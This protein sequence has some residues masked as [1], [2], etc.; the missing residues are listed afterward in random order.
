MIKKIAFLFLL[1]VGTNWSLTAQIQ[2]G[3]EFANFDTL[4]VI[5]GR[6]LTTKGYY[7]NADNNGNGKF[8]YAP[9]T[10]DTSF[11]GYWKSGWALSKVID[12]A[13]EPSD[14]TKHLYAARP[15]TGA[16]GPFDQG[17]AIGQNGSKL[18]F[19]DPVDGKNLL[20]DIG[21]MLGGFY[22]SN[23]TYAYNSM[24]LGDFIGKKFGGDSKNDPDYFTLTVLSHGRNWT[25]N[26]YLC[27]TATYPLADFTFADTAKDFILSQWAYADVT[28][29]FLFID[30]L[31]FK[32]SSSDVGQFGMNT[33]AFFAID[34]LQIFQI[35]SVEKMNK[36]ISLSVYPNP[37]EDQLNLTLEVKPKAIQILDASG[38][39]FQLPTSEWR[40]LADNSYDFQVDVSGLSSGLY[41]ISILTDGGV[42]S[43][44]FVRK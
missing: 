18:Y 9:I 11:G 13:V 22:Y 15:G 27:D 3:F 26:K 1:Q 21:L 30:S 20:A 31:E 24:L 44:S 38:K 35:E 40:V 5:D 10:W 23:T 32:L 29:E 19:V 39:S 42:V 34:A 36:S 6:D 28:S 8:F 4:K 14:Y 33:P 41:V 17:W 7:G 2:S 16:K 12:T 37:T 43:Q 25:D